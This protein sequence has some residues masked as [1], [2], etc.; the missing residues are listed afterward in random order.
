MIVRLGSLDEAPS[1]VLECVDIERILTDLVVRVP[2]GQLSF[3]GQTPSSLAIASI[4]G[5]LSFTGLAPTVI[6]T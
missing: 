5:T 1:V 2:A 6:R 4:A 3:T